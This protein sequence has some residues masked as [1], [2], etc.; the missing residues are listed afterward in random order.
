MVG[1]KHVNEV[2]IRGIVLHQ[3][4]IVYAGLL[5][6]CSLHPEPPFFSNLEEG[7]VL[8]K[9]PAHIQSIGA[10]IEVNLF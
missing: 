1:D 5:H 10:Y 2:D 7:R 9:R 3:E 6:R 4:D 8:R